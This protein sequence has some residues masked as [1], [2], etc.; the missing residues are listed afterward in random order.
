MPKYQHPKI[1]FLDMP[2]DAAKVLEAKG[3]NVSVG[4]LGEPYKVKQK[5][6]FFPLCH[7]SSL[8]HDYKEQEIIVID[9]CYDLRYASI[10]EDI[11]EPQD[12]IDEWWVDHRQGYVNPRP[13]W[14]YSVER[15]FDRILNT[16]G[17]F[18]IF[19]DALE[20]QNY[21]LGY[22]NYSVFQP[23]LERNSNNWNFLTMLGDQAHYKIGNDHGAMLNFP[24]EHTK[25]SP[26]ISLLSEHLEEATYN[27]TLSIGSWL[28]QEWLPLLKNK[29]G[30]DV[31]GLIFPSDGRKGW[32]FILPNLKKKAD[33]TTKLIE[34]I[35]PEI[36]PSLFPEQEYASW[37]HRVEYTL[38]QVNR[39]HQNIVEI[40][41]K[42]NLK[43]AVLEQEIENEQKT[44]AYL[45]NLLT[46]TGDAL[47]QAIIKTLQILGFQ[48]IKDADQELAMQGI[49]KQNREDL[50]I[51]DYETT[52]LV[53]VKGIKGFPCDD[54]A[55]AVQK[56][57]VL[58]MREWKSVNIQG[59]TII[60][61]QRH[62]PP[63]ERDNTL[64]FRQE[65][66]DVAEEQQ[67]GLLTT[68]D[69]HRL[70]RSFVQNQWNHKQIKDLFYQVGRIN[71]LPSHY[72]F[73]GIIERFI[74][75]KEILGIKIEASS[76]RLGDRIAFKLPVIFEE[77]KCESLE[78]E[79]NLIQVAEV[80]MLVGTKTHLTK[81]DVS[82]GIYV[83][84][85]TTS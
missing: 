68:W 41:E 32:I 38:P 50:Q 23:K 6:D 46:E 45:F 65:I 54:D 29:F 10:K 66:L 51:H 2:E 35:L 24:Q 75:S 14:S 78:F 63:L 9:M 39:L 53:E 73:I 33:F 20:I 64:P 74:E 34:Q 52:L 72:E 11:K 69:L 58:R 85:V 15:D 18:V 71:I 81:E 61:H 22:K 36:V 62:I 60:N 17:V 4:S 43:V 79:K 76:L 48:Q 49:E 16:G 8:P 1:L 26:I 57:V 27:C 47:V 40:R 7:T 59:L 31:A 12:G 80:G 37:I 28:K 83:Y 25:N 19:A 70:A 67:I 56:Y 13:F 5:N 3:Y 77:Q 82:I 55:L 21:Y 84:R 44:N 30:N 42:A